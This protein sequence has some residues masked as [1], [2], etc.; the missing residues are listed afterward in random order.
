MTSPHARSLSLAM[1][2]LAMSATRG[3]SDD[4]VITACGD[5][6]TDEPPRYPS[7]APKTMP[8]SFDTARLERAEQKRTRR[9]QRLS[10]S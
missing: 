5:T 6:L 10:K 2:A 4:I 1:L 8:T 3:T 7:E 9:A